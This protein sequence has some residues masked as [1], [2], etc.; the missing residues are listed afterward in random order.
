MQISSPLQMNLTNG[1][2]ASKILWLDPFAVRFSG[3]TLYGG[4]RNILYGHYFFHNVTYHGMSSITTISGSLSTFN[5]IFNFVVPTTIGNM[6]NISS[7]GQYLV[8]EPCVTPGTCIP[9]VNG[10]MGTMCEIP[11]CYGIAGNETSVCSGRGICVAP[12]VCS[13][14]TFGW[15][16]SWCDIAVCY[17]IVGN[18]SS[19]CS[20]RGTC[21]APDVCSGCTDGYTGSICD[22]PL[23]Y[24][25]AGNETLSVCSGRGTCVAPDVCSGCSDGWSGSE[26][27]SP[28]CFGLQSNDSSVCSGHGVCSVPNYCTECTV[29]WSGPNCNISA[30]GILHP[31]ST[32]GVQILA[33]CGTVLV[34]YI[35]TVII[36]KTWTGL[37]M[38]PRIQYQRVSRNEI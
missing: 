9:C 11:I 19:V 33:V 34:I 4:F 24:G 35:F 29:N 16:G 5:T 8:D 30:S 7:A 38:D 32:I 37:A 21:V 18:D 12:D 17:G 13:G 20:G 10:Y 14:C 31:L 27:E 36:I 28:I 25:I 22:I 3:D 26:C 15:D 6:L 1:A 2:Q 23:C